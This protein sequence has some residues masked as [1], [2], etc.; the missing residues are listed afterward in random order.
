MSQLFFYGTLRHIPLLETV[1]ARTVSVQPAVLQGYAVRFVEGEEFPGVAEASDGSVSGVLLEDAS[2]AD[3]DRL[4]FYE[5]YDPGG[6]ALYDLRRVTVVAEAGPAE[7][8]M[9][10]PTAACGPLGAFWD[11][12]NWL[13]RWAPTAL[14]AA[15]EIMAQFGRLT[16]EQL[17]ESYPQI[18][19]RASSEVRAARSPAPATLRSSLTRDD[20]ETQTHARPYIRY[21]GVGEEVFRFPK[22]NGEQSE[23]VL[24]AALMSADAV[25]VLPYDPKRD[26]VLLI[27]QFRF[28]V[29][30]RGDPR[31]WMLE[32]IAGRIDPGETP[33]ATAL[34]ESREE[35]DLDVRELLEIG[36]YY[37]S[38]GA[39]TE[40]L[41]SYIGIADL[42]DTAEVIAGLDEEAE[43]IRTHVIPFDHL[44]ELCASG[45]AAVGPLI[46]SAQW[47]ALNRERLAGFA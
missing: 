47:I 43:D 7:A 46:Q 17:E 27:E 13:E 11:F 39:M 32:P 22:F 2:D 35:A 44:M 3:R 23:P 10:V 42:A 8:V 38:P 16:P 4:N 36:R 41:I 12:D 28:G 31:P 19:A 29:Y 15:R 14:V 9:F 37:P 24:R 30:L 40:F 45:E 5:G 25:T 18:M 21:F 20:I 1:L 26:R 34:R 33:E 6:A